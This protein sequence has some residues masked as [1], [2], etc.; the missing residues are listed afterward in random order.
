[1]SRLYLYSKKGI[2]KIK[3]G[4]AIELPPGYTIILTNKTGGIKV[5]RN[6]LKKYID[7]DNLNLKNGSREIEI[8]RIK[9]KNYRNIY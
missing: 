7:I 5:I 6:R 4:I 1:M 9:A 8:E 3:K 2:K